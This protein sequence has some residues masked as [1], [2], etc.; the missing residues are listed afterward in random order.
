MTS[1]FWDAH[2]IIF[3]ERV[4]KGTTST[5]IVITV[6]VTFEG[7]NGEKRLNLQ[8][9]KETPRLEA[10]KLKVHE[11]FFELLPHTPNSPYLAIS[12]FFMLSDLKRVLVSNCPDWGLFDPKSFGMVLKSCKV[13]IPGITPLIA[14]MLNNKVEL[15]RLPFIHVMQICN[16]CV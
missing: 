10:V 12:I 4:G 14:S 2:E 6:I 9:K 7:W 5:A 3:I 15:L 1:I 8:K 13:A 11:L 16:A